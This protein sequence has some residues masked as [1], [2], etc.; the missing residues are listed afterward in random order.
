MRANIP[1]NLGGINFFRWPY[2]VFGGSAYS[3]AIESKAA[4]SGEFLLLL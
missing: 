1:R 3:F 2:K 4:Q